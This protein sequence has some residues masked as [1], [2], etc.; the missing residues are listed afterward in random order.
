MQ[1]PAINRKHL[2]S[3]CKGALFSQVSQDIFGREP[4][5]VDLS[6]NPIIHR[7]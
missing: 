2:A 5:F 7:A 1:T 6:S 4:G 3:L